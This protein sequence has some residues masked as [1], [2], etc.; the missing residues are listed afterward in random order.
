[1]LTGRGWACLGGGVMTYVIGTF[2]GYEQLRVLGGGFVAMVLLGALWMLRGHGLDVDRVV[3]P[4]RVTRQ[5]GPLH[6]SP[7]RAHL[8]VRN[9]RRRRSSALAVE[10]VNG[11]PQ[12]AV[13]LRLPSRGQ[14][15]LSY[16]V[17]STRRGVFDIGPMEVTRMDPLRLWR[18][19][20]QA[21]E[22]H[23]L[24]VHPR[25]HVLAL[26][27]GQ[28]PSLD[29]DT[30]EQAFDNS[31]TF[32][33]L[34]EYVPGD[35]L[36]LVHWR[37]YARTGDLLVRENIDTGIAQTTILV[38]TRRSVHDDDGFESALE[39]VASVAIAAAQVGYAVRLVS[40]C[41]TVDTVAG[42]NRAPTAILDALAELA[43]ASQ[44]ALPDR[45]SGLV[46]DRSNDVLVIVTGLAS[47]DGLIRLGAL[48]QRYRRSTIVVM[49]PGA[50]RHPVAGSLA[51]NVVRATSG[52][53]FARVWNRKAR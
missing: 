32:H 41:E 23:R 3:V 20:R 43:P 53:D 26:Q 34:R 10:L 5:S 51:A 35:D 21:G 24:W 16:P 8:S 1:M 31:V 38:D 42:G 47:P 11:R 9:R 25:Q 40:I 12:P 50:D 45:L 33:A 13:A 7:V 15:H 27:A 37:T 49:G 36:R 14:R 4:N 30:G 18:K 6:L 44:N 29:G 52:E 19:V 48:A 17:P 46:A 39:V 28:A 2:L 22:V